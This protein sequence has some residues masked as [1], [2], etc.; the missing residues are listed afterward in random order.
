[1]HVGQRLQ[2]AP[3]ENLFELANHG[4]MHQP[5]R[6]QSLATV[7]LEWPTL[8]VGHPPSSFL[9]NEHARGRV[10]GVE[11]ELPESVETSASHAA[12]VKRCRARS[13]DSVRVQRN[14]MVEKDIR[15]LMALMAWESGRHQAFCQVRRPRDMD[16]LLIQVSAASL[17]RR[18]QFIPR[19]IVNHS[20]DPIPFVLQSHRNAK[21]RETMRE[22]RG[23]V[24]RVNVPAVIAARVLEPTFFAEYVVRRPVSGGAARG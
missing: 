16:S 7:Q 5:I 8:K 10:P 20:S 4:R 1:M 14:L 11:V 23:S 17:F 22:V 3:V 15:I 6:G 24:Q 19:G 18:E 21:H 13:T 12:E 2:I 9:D